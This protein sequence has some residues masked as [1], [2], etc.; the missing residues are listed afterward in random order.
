MLYVAHLAF[1]SAAPEAVHGYLTTLIEAD[2]IDAAITGTRAHLL[3]LQDDRALFPPGTEIT[4][5]SCVEILRPSRD[6]F[7]MQFWRLTGA[8][9]TEVSTTLPDATAEQACAFQ[10]CADRSAGDSQQPAT[11]VSIGASAPADTNMPP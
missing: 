3:R 1:T 11:L 4:V 2:T 10:W 6:G 5:A 7:A 8:D 9:F